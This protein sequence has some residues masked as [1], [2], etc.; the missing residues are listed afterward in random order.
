MT[1]NEGE[2]AKYLPVE[3]V[4]LGVLHVAVQEWQ[5]AQPGVVFAV[6]LGET[7]CDI[8]LPESD[9]QMWCE[10][11]IGSSDS[12]AIDPLLLAGVAEWGLSP[13]LTAS[14][15]VMAYPK[16]YPRSCSTLPDQLALTFSWQIELHRFSA[17][18]FGWPMTYFQSIADR[19]MPV[20]R[21]RHL[22]PSAAF[23]CYGGGCSL[24]LCELRGLNIGDGVR[25][26]TF[27]NLRAGELIVLLSAG[28]AARVNFGLESNMQIS[29]L[30]Q[31]VESL[32]IEERDEVDNLQSLS[33]NI[34]DLPQMLLVEVGQVDISLGALRALSVGD[35][36]PADARFGTEVR[37]RL[38]GRVVGAGELVGCG[39]SFLVRISRWYLS[40]A[41]VAQ[42]QVD[43]VN[44][45]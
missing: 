29:E 13:L 40:P 35:I 8:W 45:G 44:T 38:N 1:P 24:S 36:L 15:A 19:V 10:E 21:P 27:G 23:A 17:L 32:L 11:T 9:W 22:L 6:T 2:V 25:I 39:D 41:E 43:T 26:Q 18:L 5:S 16:S 12:N 42:T 4:T 37:L 30:V 34:D 33:V 20:V 31:D 7:A 3:G 14:N 28:V